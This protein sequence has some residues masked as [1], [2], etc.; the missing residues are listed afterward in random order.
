MVADLDITQKAGA[1]HAV[2][3]ETA[4]LQLAAG[5]I[6]D[7]MFVKHLP[8]A[9]RDAAV[10]LAFDD[11]VINDDAAVV[12][13]HVRRDFRHPGVRIDFDFGDMAAVGPGRADRCFSECVHRVR[14]AVR[15]FFRE[16]LETDG[17]VAVA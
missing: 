15:E 12:D 2:I 4:G 7:D 17:L 1:R 8:G 3:H 11:V 16:L 6:V 9:L 13:R 10:H 14:M 5:A